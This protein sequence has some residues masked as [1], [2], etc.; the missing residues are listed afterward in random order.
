MWLG[1]GAPRE[2]KIMSP[3]AVVE[4]LRGPVVVEE[5]VDGANLGLSV[6]PDG[7]IRA[8]SRGSYLAPGRSHAQWSPLWPWLAARERSL[9]A[10]LDTNL[11]LFGE[12][13]YA[14]HSIAY[15]A[16]PDWFLVFD[17]F[18]PSTGIFWSSDRRN[19][20]ATEA[21]LHTVPE[22]FRGRLTLREVPSVIDKSPLGAGTREGVYLRQE[23]EGR[24]I[25]RAKVVS[26]EFIQQGDA[27]WTRRPLVT[28]RLGVEAGA[29]L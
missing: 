24:L 15:S 13:C 14:R 18:E 20:L 8:Q 7:R 4:F 9:V 11:M 10:A 23:R 1:D 12:W 28:N 5:K 25:T 22:V 27:H 19:T 16:L 17:V 6:G 21:G 3:H 29:P 2:D 26:R